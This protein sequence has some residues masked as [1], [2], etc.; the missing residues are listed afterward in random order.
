VND[1]ATLE[2]R[3]L[4]GIVVLNW[5][6]LELTTACLRSLQKQTYP[7][8]RVILV[9]NGSTD[10]SGR[11][12]AELFPNAHLLRL[13]T[14]EGFTGGSNAGIRAALSSDADYVLL[15]NND[16]VVAAD[17]LDELI[18]A[19]EADHQIGVVAPK[20]FFADSPRVIWYAAG[21]FNWW[22]GLS[23][24]YRRRPDERTPQ[25]PRDITFA[26]GCAMLLR[27][28]VLERVGLL[29][30]RFFAYVED[31]DITTRILRAGNRARYAPSA[32]VWHRGGG[33]AALHMGMD[34]AVR[35]AIRNKL[36]LMTKHARPWH[37]VTFVPCF[38]VRRVLFHVLRGLWTRDARLAWA[39]VAG[40]VDFL[41][42]SARERHPNE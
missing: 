34:R 40:I 6:G 42:M 24:Y 3:P 22:Q 29:D 13:K 23:S 14:N 26:T 15:L 21:S 19:A 25:S 35:L 11:A 32:R 5:N 30:E 4:V 2:S 20:I 1:R 37:W 28:S 31:A 9:D 17:M 38:G 16:T 8:Y 27:S 33:T 10:G 39:P 12:L 36:L 18:R 7:N 41:C